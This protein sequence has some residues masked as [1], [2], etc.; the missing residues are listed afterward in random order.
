[1]SPG[2]RAKNEDAVI[3]ACQKLVDEGKAEWV[4]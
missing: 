3:A 1:M 4:R 2:Q